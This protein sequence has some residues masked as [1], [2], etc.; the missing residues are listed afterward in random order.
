MPCPATRPVGAA[1]FSLRT[2]PLGWGKRPIPLQRRAVASI[3]FPSRVHPPLTPFLSGVNVGL[4]L[5]LAVFVV[6]VQSACAPFR[7]LCKQD[8]MKG[9][10]MRANGVPW[11]Q[12]QNCTCLAVVASSTAQ[13]GGDGIQRRS[14]LF[15]VP[16]L[17]SPSIPGMRAVVCADAASR[18]QHSLRIGC[19]SRGQGSA[20]ISRSV[21][22][23]TTLGDRRHCRLLASP[24]E[25]IRTIMH[26]EIEKQ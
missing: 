16:F 3:G 6:A 5:R 13:G 9:E 11:R 8:A 23:K 22:S 24:Y 7:V 18:F 12:L 10:R 4:L 15:A 20:R 1:R 25:Y 26:S 19:A 2:P 14:F 21:F 17:W